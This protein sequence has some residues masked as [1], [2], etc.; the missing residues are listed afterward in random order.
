M[1]LEINNV[2]IFDYDGVIVDSIE[3]HARNF[4]ESLHSN[5]HLRIRNREELLDL[6][7]GNFYEELQ[8]TGLTAEHIEVVI[9]DYNIKQ[10]GSLKNIQLFPGIKESITELAK[11]NT[12]YIVTS[13]ASHVVERVLKDKRINFFQEV[14][15][16]EQEKSKTKKIKTLTK[17]FPNSE[18]FY[19]GDTKGD[20]I[21][22]KNA[23]VK[24]VGVA[25]GWHGE[26]RLKETNPDYILKSPEELTELFAKRKVKSKLHR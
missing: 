22:G 6:Y 24:T 7:E 10:K 20:I 15:G 4:I 3:L 17:Q 5:G 1:S 16:A 9:K 14:L 11:N 13:N 2:L 19:I 21:E 23:G 26:K 8:G 25:W 12:M 18:S